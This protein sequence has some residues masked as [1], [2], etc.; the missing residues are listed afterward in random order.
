MYAIDNEGRYTIIDHN[1]NYPVYTAWDIGRTDATAIWFYQVINDVPR[2]IDF[3]ECTLKNL[4][5]FASR[6]LG[7]RIQVDLI[8]DEVIVTR[9]EKLSNFAHRRAYNY[10]K[11]YLPHDARHKT[12]VAKGKS[13]QQQM[14]AVFGLKMV[15]ITPNLSIQ[16]GIKAGRKLLQIC[17]I[18]RKCEQGFNALKEYKYKYDDT[19]KVYSIKPLHD[20]ASN[21]AD[22]LRYVAINWRGVP[23]KAPPKPKPNPNIMDNGIPIAEL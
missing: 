4:D 18:D 17:Q 12:Q 11:H 8:A 5:Y 3:E 14:R 9:G 22:A 13:T 21:P 16:D 1:P 2:L 19:N 6:I 20:W 23:K 15:G 10:G 7:I